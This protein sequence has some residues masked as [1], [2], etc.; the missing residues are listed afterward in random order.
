MNLLPAALT[1][2]V[3]VATACSR[4]PSPPV[5]DGSTPQPEVPIRDAGA[6]LQTDSMH[7]QL[8]A[9]GSGPARFALVFTYANTGPDTVYQLDCSRWL[10]PVLQRRDSVG[11][12][13]A[14]SIVYPPCLN[15]LA[16]PPGGLRQDTLPVCRPTSSTESSCAP[17][18]VPG[19][20]GIYR[21]KLYGVVLHYDSRTGRGG[22]T[23]PEARRISNSF[24]ITSLK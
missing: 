17:W 21:L 8:A 9:S 13:G 18:S 6:P 2:L 5:G 11:W 3:T 1:L 19:I 24:L 7:Y 4:S 14:Y 23:L 12:V 22:D 16:L 10:N 20:D 15:V